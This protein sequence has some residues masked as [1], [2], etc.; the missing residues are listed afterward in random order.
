MLD[1]IGYAAGFFLM[2]SFL[3]QVI[4]TATTRTTEG[5]SVSMLVITLISGG[6]YE[7][8]AYLL[9][10]TPVVIMN[11]IFVLTVSIQ[12]VMTLM[13]NRSSGEQE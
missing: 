9:G 12:L 7:I 10:L 8:Y 1:L 13:I 11:G 2:W 3:P 6:L 4:K 5:L